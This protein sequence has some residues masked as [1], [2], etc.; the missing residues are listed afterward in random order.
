MKYE[1]SNDLASAES[2]LEQVV[3]IDEAVGH[4]DLESDRAELLRIQTKRQNL[5]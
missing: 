3:V 4:P 1:V 2:Q 5:N